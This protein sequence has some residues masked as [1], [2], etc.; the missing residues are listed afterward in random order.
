LQEIIGDISSENIPLHRRRGKQYLAEI[1]S[2]V[3]V[4]NFNSSLTYNQVLNTPDKIKWVNAIEKEVNNMN[5]YG[6]WDV[7]DT[8]S[9]DKPLNCTWVFKIKP[10]ASNQAK[11]HKACLCVQGFN[12]VFGRDYNHTYVPTGKL[13]SLCLLITFALQ[14]KFQFHQID[15]KCAFL[16]APIR[17]RITLNPPPVLNVLPGKLLLLKKA[18]YGLK[19]APKSWHLTLLSWLLHHEKTIVT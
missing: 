17:E 14:N 16:N 10:E 1:D 8:T 9:E 7:I 12:K 6:V 2:I 15:V 4:K 11:E 18:L 5:D 19:Q 13:T 3:K